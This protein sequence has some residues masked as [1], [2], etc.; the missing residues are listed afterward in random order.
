MLVADNSRKLV[1]YAIA[2]IEKRPPIF[3]LKKRMLIIDVFVEKNYRHRGLGKEFV[4]KAIAF[5]KSKKIRIINLPVSEK[6]PK[7]IK[8]Y[9]RMG[10]RDY[11][12]TMLLKT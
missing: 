11:D 8:L 9:K 3:K 1:G 12:K 6:N 4:Q 7:A 10:F 2:R 5:A